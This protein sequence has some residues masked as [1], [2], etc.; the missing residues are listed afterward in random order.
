[1]ADVFDRYQRC[2]PQIQSTF[3]AIPNTGGMATVGNGDCC[4]ITDLKTEPKQAEIK[5]PDKTGSVDSVM[6]Q[7]GR[8]IAS[9]TAS[10]SAAG[11][12][13]AGTPPD[14]KNFLQ[15]IFG[16]AGVVVASTS[17][18]WSLAD[19]LYYLAVY[20]FM[21][22]I[23][24][25]TQMC[26]FNTLLQKME[27]TFGG[28]VPTLTF[29]G[30]SGWV[31]DNDQAADV[32]TNSSAKGGLTAFPAEPSAPVVNGTH[33]PGFKVQATIDG[34]VYTNILSG[35]VALS[36]MRELLKIGNTEFAGAGAPGDREV[37]LD[38]SMTDNDS[39][40]LRTLKQK[41]ISRTPV[42]ATFAIGTIAGNRWVHQLNNIIVPKPVYGASGTRRTVSFTGAVAYPSAINARDQYTLAIN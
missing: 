31:Y 17:V 39:A 42:N 15:A 7:G 26:A 37:T 20:N 32:G 27:A 40:Q 1:M 38:F 2:Y 36:V 12:G 14:C 9:L 19:T 29:S 21:A 11:N 41:A 4:L 6:A 28:D 25:A 8:R 33:P 30:E 5:R 34:N 35:K 22:T 24:N 23:A 18:T 13:T 3:D 10:L 16:A